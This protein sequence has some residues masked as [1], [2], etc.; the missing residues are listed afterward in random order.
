MHAG[1]FATL[2]TLWEFG[3]RTGI[4][5]PLFYPRPS[6]ILA[7]FWRIYVL[8]A[9]IWYH[10]AVSLGLVLAGLGDAPSPRSAACTA[11]GGSAELKWI[12]SS[13]TGGF[14]AT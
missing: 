13:S 6:A 1:I 5:D 8:Q 14:V 2:L 12:L 10:L 3:A 4:L 7:S 9:N 11:G